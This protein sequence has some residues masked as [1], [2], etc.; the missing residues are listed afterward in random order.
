MA[1]TSVGIR[2]RRVYYKELDKPAYQRF[3]SEKKSQATTAQ[4]ETKK[5]IKLITQ[6]K[7]EQKKEAE[8]LR[9][10]QRIGRERATIKQPS[11][12]TTKRTTIGQERF[13]T[14]IKNI[15]IRKRQELQ[16]ETQK[17]YQELNKKIE[18][19]NKEIVSGAE[20]FL[21]EKSKV[22]KTPDVYL[23]GKK[24]ETKEEIEKAI[25]EV[26]K[27]YQ[28]DYEK[29]I[30]DAASEKGILVIKEKQGTDYKIKDLDNLLERINKTPAPYPSDNFG[31]RQ[32]GYA[33]YPEAQA[34]FGFEP[35][36]IV[37]DVG[38][39]KRV[40]SVGYDFSR[41]PSNLE[42]YDNQN[43]NMEV[44]DVGIVTQKS[45]QT[46]AFN[47]GKSTATDIDFQEEIREGREKQFLAIKESGGR[48][49][50]PIGESINDY[51]KREQELIRQQREEETEL[52]NAYEEQ[53]FGFRKARASLQRRAETTD[54]TQEEYDAEYKKLNKQYD[55]LFKQGEELSS[56][57][58]ARQDYSE[59][60]KN[61]TSMEKA[62]LGENLLDTSFLKGIKRGS[63]LQTE[64][65][66]AATPVQKAVAGKEPGFFTD[67]GALIAYPG[68]QYYVSGVENVVGP[69]GEV[70]SKKQYRNIFQD[71]T[72]EDIAAPTTFAEELEF[73]RQFG[74]RKG[75]E[76][77]TRPYTSKE[78]G[79]D[80]FTVGT[81][82][83]V[84]TGIGAGAGF[85]LG[86]PKGAVAGAATGFVGGAVGGLTDV[87]TK[88]VV[89]RE[90]GSESVAQTAGL[91]AGIGAGII[92]GA[93]LEKSIAK[94]LK[95]RGVK[96]IELDYLAPSKQPYPSTKGGF[97]A[98]Y[99]EAYYGKPQQ[100]LREQFD[101][102]DE[103]EPLIIRTTTQKTNLELSPLYSSYEEIAPFYSTEMSSIGVPQFG[104]RPRRFTLFGG[105]DD[106]GLIEIAQPKRVEQLPISEN[107]RTINFPEYVKLR[108]SVGV[109][110]SLLGKIDDSTSGA[111]LQ[112]K[113]YS[114][115]K[116]GSRPFDFRIFREQLGQ[117]KLSKA[118]IDSTL[119]PGVVYPSTAFQLKSGLGIKV[120]KELLP[121]NLKDTIIEPIGQKGIRQKYL[122]FP[123][124]FAKQ[125][126]EV[127]GIYFYKLTS[128][129]DLEN[130]GFVARKKKQFGSFLSK[131]QIENA[132]KNFQSSLDYGQSVPILT[133]GRLA[134]LAPKKYYDGYSKQRYV[135][136]RYSFRGLKDFSQNYNPIKSISQP[137]F[138]RSLERQQ[139]KDLVD[140]AKPF[141]GQQQ[142]KLIKQRPQ[143]YYP[144]RYYSGPLSFSGTPPLN[145]NSS[146]SR[147]RK[148][149]IKRDS[150]T[151]KKVREKP[152]GTFHAYTR[153]NKNTRWVKVT[154]KPLPYNAAFNQGIRVAD[155]TVSRTVKLEPKSR[156]SNVFDDPF[157]N[158]VKFRRRKTGSKVPGK[159]IQLVER[160][161][162]AIDTVGEK[163]GLKAAKFVKKGLWF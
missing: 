160:S 29:Q 27:Q 120:E 26:Q 138:L 131:K 87:F 153:K 140:Y 143:T 124:A 24:A 49:S 38:Q 25:K 77:A 101:F 108:E 155:N 157:I 35:N 83:G 65:E 122:G 126:S 154:K 61:A 67:L 127:A 99:N 57:F 135:Q 142:P 12:L 158:D 64:L 46:S 45:L 55:D 151:G 90:S 93:T 19:I 103:G 21:V 149:R 33:L 75:Y 128:K 88:E 7:Q 58:S 119:E 3:V 60:L 82:I 152:M 147:K 84:G 5:R 56:M 10:K 50:S 112:F 89:L 96:R 146:T 104:N 136:P 40:K 100:Y 23:K 17:Q 94:S 59:Y 4:T 51:Y 2:R 156:K 80:L 8:L 123:Q 97:N 15:G 68:Q 42:L 159:E 141:L 54:M 117:E 91:L 79:Q 92:S 76:I 36:E 105:V 32:A 63:V 144:P 137:S 139:P 41:I 121:F 98:L 113:E 34:S 162:F 102:L 20:N 44:Q 125:D 110:L 72:L 1:E 133:P 81:D 39:N 107:Y 109:D 148:T 116:S 47:Q 16:Q 11:K 22:I 145:Y 48:P 71:Y 69:T 37:Y 6:T 130:L 70:Y 150:F 62:Y 13:R 114:M 78:F 66:F 134:G 74:F 43:I 106:E 73:R 161:K 30:I 18:K 9:R 85:L 31:A 14:D 111:A 86:G 118:F 163:R 28:L 129:S 132:R 95:F 53:D 52:I 115:V